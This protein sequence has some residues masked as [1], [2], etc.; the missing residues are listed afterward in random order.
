MGCWK[1]IPKTDLFKNYRGSATENE[2][3]FK[4]QEKYNNGSATKNIF[5]VAHAFSGI[6]IIIFL[7][8]PA[9]ECIFRGV[10]SVDNLAGTSS[11]FVQKLKKSKKFT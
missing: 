1:V 7:K 11:N 5:S 2:L 6:S 3:Y 10:W 8:A 9:L 4:W